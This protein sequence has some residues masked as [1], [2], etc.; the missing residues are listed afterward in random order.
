MRFKYGLTI[1][2]AVGCGF[3][4]A[5]CAA[6][7]GKPYKLEFASSSSVTI[8][9]DPMLTNMGE[10][11]NAAQAHCETFGKD[12]LPGKDIESPWRLISMSFNCKN[13]TK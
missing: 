1:L 3:F 13:R 8:T 5:S 4:L 9:Y 6:V 12:A 11:Q 10:V 7:W 2:L